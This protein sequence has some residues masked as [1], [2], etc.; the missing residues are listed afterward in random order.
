MAF[1]IFKYQHT[2][3]AVLSVKRKRFIVVSLVAAVL[4]S[5]FF[6]PQGMFLFLLPLLS[7]FTMPKQLLVGSRYLICGPYIVYYANV[8]KLS[9]SEKQGTLR[10]QSANGKSLLIEREK[11]PTGARKA[12]KVK[13]NKANKFN[14]ISAKII[15]QVQQASPDVTLLKE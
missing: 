2:G 6:F 8:T 10:L 5:I 12:H 1:A 14:K 4:A 7:Y 13:F 9:L 11:F 3:S 15:K